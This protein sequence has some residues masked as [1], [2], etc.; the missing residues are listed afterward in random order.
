MNTLDSE[1]NALEVCVDK[2]PAAQ[3]ELVDTAYRP[4]VQMSDLADRLGWTSM[5]LYKKLHRIRLSLM[6]CVRRELSMERSS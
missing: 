3:R 2:L 4:G 1:Q 6:E 5:A